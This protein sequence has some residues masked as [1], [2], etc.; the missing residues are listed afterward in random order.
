MR[1]SQGVWSEQRLTDAINQTNQFYAIPYGP[2]GTAPTD[3]VRAFELYFERL[4][5]A[6]LGKIKRPDLLIFKMLDKS[7]VDSFL[8]DIGGSKELPFILET[9]LQPLIKRSLI[10]V[11]CE[12]SLWVAEKMP[13]YH[14]EFNHDIPG[15]PIVLN[16][17]K[18]S[19]KNKKKNFFLKEFGNGRQKKRF[20][21]KRKRNL[22][23]FG[24]RFFLS[25]NCNDTANLKDYG[26]VACK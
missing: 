9:E 13:D 26:I 17:L 19:V 24:K 21:K 4:E 18:R 11:E 1:W 12:N 25:R 6:G 15:Y 2:S 3:D 10:A 20:N 5:A 23:F 7:Y 14:K 16:S 8:K 22:R